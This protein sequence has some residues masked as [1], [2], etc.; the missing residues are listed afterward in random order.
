MKTKTLLILLVVLVVG[1]AA[2]FFGARVDKK[3]TVSD[4]VVPV[5]ALTE[6][7]V[8]RMNITHGDASYVLGKDGSIWTVDGYTIDQ[9]VM[10]TLWSTLVASKVLRVAASNPDNHAKFEVDAVSGARVEF[11]GGGDH[12]VIKGELIVGKSAG[13]GKSYIRLPESDEV[14]EVEGSLSV[15]FRKERDDWR[16]KTITDLGEAII[17]RIELT[18]GITKVPLVK[19]EDVWVFSDQAWKEV[20]Q[21]S[22]ESFAGSVRSLRASGFKDEASD[23]EVEPTYFIELFGEDDALLA[24]LYITERDGAEPFVWREGDDTVFTISS[25]TEEQVIKERSDFVAEK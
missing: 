5:F 13:A 19:Q 22:V 23:E 24:I 20:D 18:R 12:K 8:G 2:Y 9:E 11:F 15:V 10:N 4:I 16:D 25:F 6:Q 3:A 7:D 17:D 21:E 14:L 1:V